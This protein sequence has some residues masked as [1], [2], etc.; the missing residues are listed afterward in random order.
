MGAEEIEIHAE[1]GA[2]LRATVMEP[3]GDTPPRAVAVLS[4]AMFARRTE[5]LKRHAD[6]L[7]AYC[8]DGMAAGL[9][10]KKY[11]NVCAA[12]LET[13]FLPK[14]QEGRKKYL[15]GMLANAETKRRDVAA[16]RLE[17][18]KLAGLGVER[19]V[20]PLQ[21]KGVAIA[22]ADAV[23]GNLDRVRRGKGCQV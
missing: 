21:P 2:V 19:T 1:G 17:F 18:E 14:Y 3:G 10:G 20:S 22:G 7:H 23:F 13:K 8:Q 6:G 11:K 4:H 12:N 9:S 16:D 5:W 15:N